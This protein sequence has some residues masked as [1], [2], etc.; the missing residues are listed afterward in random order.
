M[1]EQTIKQTACEAALLLT[2]AIRELSIPQH[3]M[4]I[5]N[6]LEESQRVSPTY[7]AAIRR[8]VMTATVIGVYRV[9]ETRKHFLIPWLFSEQELR[10]L[11]LP[12]V[13]QFVRDWSAF[14]IVRSQWAAHAQAKK[15]TATRPGR[16]IEPSVLGRALERTGI[17]N[18][19]EFLRRVRDELIPAVERV[20]DKILKT[21]AQARDFITT[22]YPQALQRGAIDEEQRRDTPL[23]LGGTK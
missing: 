8:I 9:N 14:E 23:T 11:G 20:R 4:T 18:E 7:A 12:N 6:Q 1:D 17:G 16:L 19:E 5:A 22:G 2:E 3:L 10:L 13:E 21:H 15:S